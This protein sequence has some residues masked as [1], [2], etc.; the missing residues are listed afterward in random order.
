MPPSFQRERGSRHPRNPRVTPALE[1][2][3]LSP[4]ILG[5]G[6]AGKGTPLQCHGSLDLMSVPESQVWTH[7]LKRRALVQLGPLH[8]GPSRHHAGEMVFIR[9]VG[10]SHGLIWWRKPIHMFQDYS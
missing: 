1:A 4:G 9:T 8:Q 2:E 3:A 10:V 6:A 5:G 7:G